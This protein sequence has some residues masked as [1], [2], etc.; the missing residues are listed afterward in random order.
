MKKGDCRVIYF[1]RPIGERGPIKIGCAAVSELRRGVY[2]TWSPV[3]LELLAETSGG[4]RHEKQLHKRFQRDRRHGEWFEWSKDLEDMINQI[5]AGRGFSEIFAVDPALHDP[6]AIAGMRAAGETYAAIGLK[7][8][9]SR[10]RI[11][12]L[13]KHAAE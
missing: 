13:L 2:E 1:L 10:Q 3:R 7:V 4:F 11:H 9:V 8:G 6:N 12:Q 5:K